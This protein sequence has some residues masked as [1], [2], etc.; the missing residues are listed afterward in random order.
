MITDYLNDNEITFSGCM[1][2]FS[3]INN[4][5]AVNRQNLFYTA[6]SDFYRNLGI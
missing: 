2:D 4:E 5:F 6:V 1:T 3:K